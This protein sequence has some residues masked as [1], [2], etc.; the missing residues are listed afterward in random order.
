MGIVFRT[1]IF[2]ILCFAFCFSPTYAQTNQKI[3]SLQNLLNTSEDSVKVEILLQ[4]AGKYVYEDTTKLHL[5]FHQAKRLA[6]KQKKPKLQGKCHQ[7]WASYLFR[8]RGQ[9]VEAIQYYNSSINFFQKSQ[10]NYHE[11]A[12]NLYYLGFLY[13]FMGD[14]VS[15]MNC[16]LK[17]AK[18]IS[19]YPNIKL[20]AK[21]NTLFGHVYFLQKDFVQAQVHQNKAIDL[22]HKEQDQ[23]G[24]ATNLNNLAMTFLGMK[25]YEKSIKTN[26]QAI[27]IY[28]KLQDSLSMTFPLHNIG[29]TYLKM[30][31]YQKALPYFE[32][33]AR[34]YKQ[35]G[36]TS[37]IALDYLG[38]AL[39]HVGLGNVAKS[40]KYAKEAMKFAKDNQEYTSIA[41][42][43]EVLAK[44]DSIRG[45][46][47][48]AMQYYRT[49]TI[50]RDSLG[51]KEK[52]EQ[53]TRI[54]AIYDV[55]KKETENSI[56]KAEKEH[57][58]QTI[59]QQYFV[60]IIAGLALLF[61]L[62][63]AVVLYRANKKIKLVNKDLRIHQTQIAE[64]NIEL[65]AIIQV[66]SLQKNSLQTQHKE[67]TDSIA[68]AQR[69]QQA[70]LPFESLFED[71]F[72]IQNYFV[73]YKP[74]NIVSGDFYWLHKTEEEKPKII[75]IVADCTG[76]GVPGAFMSMIGIQILQEI[77]IQENIMAPEKILVSLQRQIIHIL[78]QK[79][80]KTHD[81]MD[82]SILCIDKM[83]Q[84]VSY[85]GAMSIGFY[86]QDGKLFTLSGD[87]N[88]IGGVYWEGESSYHATEI[89]M[90]RATTFYLFSD[91]FQDQ[92]GGINNKKFTRKR[93][94]E[95]LLNNS[96]E[97][98][99]KQKNNLET[100]ITKWIDLAKETQTDDITI[101]GI[102]C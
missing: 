14:Y 91:G 9:H 7:F 54:K 87:K 68:Y 5:Y 80:N 64:Q 47:K 62:G 23:D 28:V 39:C 19:I 20:E 81:G 77:I 24:I 76:H 93:L 69:I 18:I 26:Q 57:K 72:G 35:S 2:S 13:S 50:I 48:R 60:I 90:D 59:H 99:A 101:V 17:M 37:D 32:I 36:T 51:T 33:S 31:K 27:D 15:S 67:I 30:Q 89:A 55:D 58:Q 96:Q 3:D 46:W 78:Q 75:L 1:Y 10:G 40:E 41:E 61:C 82:V 66:V 53:I 11:I 85:A 34:I 97:T 79:Q 6:E 56:L 43:Y 38:I 63:M 98:M 70:I 21:N 83:E 92:F 102:R 12:E 45:N 84:K 44:V 65:Q 8:I 86:I 29:D 25:N 73:L 100:T 71:I 94:K 95:I 16:A 4:M 74:R 88:P 52:I 49:A 22:L 42:S